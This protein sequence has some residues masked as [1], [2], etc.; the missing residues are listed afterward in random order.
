MKTHKIDSL[1]HGLGLISVW[2]VSV[3]LRLRF[4]PL[5]APV[6]ALD[7]HDHSIPI[8]RPCKPRANKQKSTPQPQP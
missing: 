2:G 6:S 1:S 7:P 4:L 5:W 3:G 8:S